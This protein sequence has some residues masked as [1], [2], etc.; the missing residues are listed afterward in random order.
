MLHAPSLLVTLRSALEQ[1]PT[2]APA[3]WDRLA[4]VLAPLVE[5]PE[6]SLIFTVRSDTLSRH[7]GEVSFP[8]GLVKQWVIPVSW[9][10]FTVAGIIGYRRFREGRRPEAAAWIGA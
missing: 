7:A 10:L 1:T 5:T 6:P 8:G 3:S 9:A 2:H 4:A